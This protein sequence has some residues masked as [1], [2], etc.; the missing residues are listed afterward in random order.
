MKKRILLLTA[1]AGMGYVLLTSYAGGP[2]PLAGNRTGA[3]GA[4]ATANCATGCH[5]TGTST[6]VTITLDSAGVTTTRYKPGMT[7]TVKIHGV[8]TSS[9]P[10]FGFQFAAVSGTGA[11]QV[12]AGTFPSSGLPSGVASHSA[13]S[14]DIIEHTAGRNGVPAGTYDVQFTWVAPSTNVGNITMYSTLNAVNGNNLQDAA[15]IS[16][17]TSIT[18]T[19]IVTTS[20]EQLVNN[21]GITAY[22]NPVVNA[23]TL[24]AEKAGTYMVNVY[25]IAGRTI[26]TEQMSSTGSINTANWAAGIYQVAVQKDG[27]MQV[28]PVVK[29]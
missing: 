11:S 7:Y 23:L 25:D 21:I 9:L 13:S 24:Q 4:T 15:D 17:N 26:A 3:K 20:V 14:L 10:K 6:T 29:Q 5:G 19:P 1:I 2:A 16:G 8:N 22:P 28:I 18:L 27:N 12:Q